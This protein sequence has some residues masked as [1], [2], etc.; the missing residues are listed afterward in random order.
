LAARTARPGSVALDAGTK[1]ATASAGAA[2]LSKSA[3]VITTESLT[4]AQNATYTLTLTNSRIAAADQVF[5][6]VSLGTATTGNPTITTVRPQAG[7]VV[8]VMQNI[9]ATALNGNVRISFIVVKN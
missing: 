5:A 1:T 2:T 7:S 4:T 8:I 9:S 3:G 6:S